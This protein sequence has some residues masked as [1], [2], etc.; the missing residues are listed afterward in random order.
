MIISP[1]SPWI[2]VVYILAC[3]PEAQSRYHPLSVC[4]GGRFFKKKVLITQA[5][6]RIFYT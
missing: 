6:Y 1:V 2:R 5:C 4:L 3:K